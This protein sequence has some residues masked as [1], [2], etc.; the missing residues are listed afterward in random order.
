MILKPININQIKNP[1]QILRS[2][3]CVTDYSTHKN[4]SV[5][6]I[7]NNFG[8]R[9][10]FGI[11]GRNDD[12]LQ[13]GFFSIV[14]NTYEYC[15]YI[16][17]DS[18]GTRRTVNV[19]IR[20]IEDI[21][22]ENVMFHNGIGYYC[23]GNT[24]EAVASYIRDTKGGVLG[25]GQYP[26]K[27]IARKYSAN[28]S[29]DLFKNLQIALPKNNTPQREA[30]KYTFG[31]EFE[32]SCGYIPEHLCYKY[33]LIPLRDGSIK[34][35]EYSTVVLDNKNGLSLLKE[36]IELLKAYTMFDKDCSLHMHLG[37]Y[38]IEPVHIFV[39]DVLGHIIQDSLEQYIPHW[40]FTSENYK[41]SH[42][43]YCKKLEPF[44]NFT[45]LYYTASCGT[46]YMGS[47]QQP[48]PHD[49]NR[50]AK[51]NI[52]VRYVWQN[53]VNM[54]FYRG[55]KTVEYRFL[56]PTYN[57]NKIVNW[58]YAFNAFL[59]FAET[60]SK[61]LL[62]QYKTNA[63]DLVS[64]NI[65]EKYLMDNYGVSK[66]NSDNILIIMNTVYKSGPSGV[67]DQ[68]LE[69]FDALKFVSSIQ[70]DNDDYIGGIDHLDKIIYSN[71]L[72]E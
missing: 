24:P 36:Q 34:G 29:L 33:G 16:E 31:M 10:A 63:I 2:M 12:Q 18:T 41:T 40:T 59:Q 55:C 38:P 35:I 52:S 13:L 25:N 53:I 15:Q 72:N 50:S 6:E 17:V 32:T 23:V 19:S 69:F 28:E 49:N 37:G 39:L 71:V 7:G 45:D 26:Y 9:Y 5:S 11:V 48:H 68:L 21:P 30:L 64:Y 54:M 67:I 27:T 4:V 47:L 58:L 51:W 14:P 60:V 44:N 22:S 57:F 46:R 1:S 65:V 8:T 3:S 56:R 70:K 20:D 66:T 61:A 43:N 62:K 42:K